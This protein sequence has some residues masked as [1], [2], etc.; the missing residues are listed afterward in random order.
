MGTEMSLQPI[1]FHNSLLIRMLH[2]IKHDK[3]DHGFVSKTCD[4]SS[5]KDLLQREDEHDASAA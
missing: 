3:K 4:L 2:S 1:S 5:L